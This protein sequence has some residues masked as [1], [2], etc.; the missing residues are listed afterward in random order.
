LYSRYL[1]HLKGKYMAKANKV[2]AKKYS[3]ITKAMR[4]RY[5][6]PLSATV[7]GTAVVGI[8]SWLLRS[9]GVQVP[10]D[11]IAWGSSLASVAVWHFMPV[12]WESPRA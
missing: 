6:A 4:T 5:A 12:E 1:N 3:N 9:N 11:V 7:I 2:V 10:N 8:L